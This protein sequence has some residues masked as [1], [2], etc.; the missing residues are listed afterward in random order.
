MNTNKPP[1]ELGIIVHAALVTF[2]SFANND[3]PDLRVSM[4]EAFNWHRNEDGIIMIFVSE[5]SMEVGYAST[6]KFIDEVYDDVH[7]AY[8]VEQVHKTNKSYGNKF[9]IFSFLFESN[10]LLGGIDDVDF[11]LIKGKRFFVALSPEI[12]Q[13]VDD[14]TSL[15]ED[16][17]L[18]K[19]SGLPSI[20]S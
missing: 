1:E 6:A 11:E 7:N 2:L 4:R 3:M 20:K 17:D 13:K 15:F 14:I 18:S 19:G 12:I 10:R 5:K 8:G 16:V 9:P